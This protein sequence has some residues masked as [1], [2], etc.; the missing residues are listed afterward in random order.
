MP[1]I[2]V[3]IIGDPRVGKTSLL[4]RLVEDRFDEES[5]ST[6][7]VD[8]SVVTIN[9]R[10]YT[11]W[12]TAG[13]EEYSHITSNFYRNAD[14]VLL[15]HDITRRE[16][17]ESLKNWILRVHAYC[18]S[19]IPILILSNKCDLEGKQSTAK[20]DGVTVKHISTSAKTGEGFDQIK[21]FLDSIQVDQTHESETLSF[22]KLK[23]QKKEKKKDNCCH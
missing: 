14:V 3:I 2:K 12:D 16:S 13:Q 11:L 7:G 15:L 5:I 22:I 9:N 8:M 10:K 19:D 1:N 17:T 4:N 21:L 20:I 23:P 18:K 6:T